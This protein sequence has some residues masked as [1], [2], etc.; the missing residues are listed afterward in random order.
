[1]MTDYSPH[2]FRIQRY[3]IHDGPGIRTTLFFQGCPLHC[4]WCHNPESQA[5]D[6]NETLM[7]APGLIDS[8]IR[9]IEKDLIYYDG[10][11]G[12][13]TFSGGE[14]LCRP[15]L[16][17]A[18]LAAC[19]EREIHTCLDTSGHAPFRILEPAARA[20][21]LVLYDIKIADEEDHKRLTGRSSRLILD[22]LKQLS[23]LNIPVRLRFPLVPSMTDSRENIGRII[24]FLLR[25]TGY[26]DIHILPFH[27]TG[28]GKY[29]QLNM[30]NHATGINP[31]GP[32]AVESA[33]RMFDRSGFNTTIG[34]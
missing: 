15:G 11:G 26:R 13:A 33:V 20:A 10:S 32:D 12:G 23:E 27:N 25:N 4:R 19:R 22:N 14:P 30:K 9:E 21:D 7:P 18:L 3:S 6:G 34:G 1:M 2:I 28:E 31:P 24:D 5:R 8:L 29:R 16:L 17:M